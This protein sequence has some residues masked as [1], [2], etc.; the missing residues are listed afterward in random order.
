MRAVV[1]FPC[2]HCMGTGRREPTLTERWTL[3]AV[4]RQWALTKDISTRLKAIQG[5]PTKIPALCNRLVDLHKRGLLERRAVTGK[6]FEWR[7]K[8]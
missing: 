1:T 3:M 2:E 6:S 4:S 7:L 8:P 5:F